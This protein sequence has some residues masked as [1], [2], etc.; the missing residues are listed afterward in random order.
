MHWMVLHRP[1]ELAPTDVHQYGAGQT[2]DKM[3]GDYPSGG[4]IAHVHDVWKAAAPNID[5]LAPDIYFPDFPDILDRY[6]RNGNPPFVPESIAG[7]GGAANVFYAM[8]IGSIGYSPYAI[9]D[10]SD[11]NG[12]IA[13][14]YDFLSEIAPMVL[15]HQASGTIAGVWLSPDRPIEDVIRRCIFLS[16]ARGMT[17]L[18][19]PRCR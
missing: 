7:S 19:P 8:G 12:P 11:P 4:A 2:Q 6:R 9:E 1:V 16:R 15:E 18:Q 17:R 3:P 5:I 14:A 10:Q 13:K